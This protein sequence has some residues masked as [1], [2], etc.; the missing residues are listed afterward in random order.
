MARCLSSVNHKLVLCTFVVHG[1]HQTD[2]Y[3]F[4]VLDHAYALYNGSGIHVL[5]R[6]YML[7]IHVCVA[8]YGMQYV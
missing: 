1:I 2:L 4:V 3:D 6:V 8:N 5:Y 7:Y